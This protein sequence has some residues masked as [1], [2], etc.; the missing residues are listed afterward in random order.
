MD[1]GTLLQDYVDVF[2]KL[3]MDL[4]TVEIKKDEET[5]ASYLLFSLTSKFCDIE[6]Q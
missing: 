4:Q 6:N 2:N 3:V 5:L 1:L